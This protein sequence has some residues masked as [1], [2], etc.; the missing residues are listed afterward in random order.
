MIRLFL[1]LGLCSSVAF[2]SSRQIN[3]FKPKSLS[4]RLTI[5]QEEISAIRKN[6]FSKLISHD[7]CTS[8]TYKCERCSGGGDGGGGEGMPYELT[9]QYLTSNTI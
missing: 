7:Y 6:N 4:S 5:A 8:C 3:S 2:A 1:V 9:H